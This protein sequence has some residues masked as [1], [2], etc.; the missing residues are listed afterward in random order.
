MI[1][2]GKIKKNSQIRLG[3]RRG[4]NYDLNSSTR[5][6]P[7][8]V[9]EADVFYV[10][11]YGKIHIEEVKVSVPTLRD[12]LGENLD[13]LDNLKSWK[14]LDPNNRKVAV[15]IENSKNWTDI[16]STVKTVDSAGVRSRKSIIKLLIARE[17]PIR[18][19]NKYF[20]VNLLRLIDNSMSKL[21]IEYMRK[22]RFDLFSKFYFNKSDINH[23][24]KIIRDAKAIK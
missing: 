17:I 8:P 11:I 23:Y 7:D 1:R 21:H 2:K 12:R 24:K 3:R 13:Q 9:N 6:D 15:V 16:F 10:D 4:Q 20:T 14:D 22:G 19:A 18:I 5:L